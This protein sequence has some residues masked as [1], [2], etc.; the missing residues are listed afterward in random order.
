[1]CCPGVVGRAGPSPG[2]SGGLRLRIGNLSAKGAFPMKRKWSIAFLFSLVGLCLLFALPAFTQNTTARGALGGIVQDTTSATVPDASVTVTGPIGSES[3]VTND[4]GRFLFPSLI[5]GTYSVRV[6]KQGF[7]V[8]EIKNVE[9]LINSTK[10][11]RVTIEP[12]EISQT[13][14]VIA[15]VFTVDATSAAVS[16]DLPDTFY[17]DVPL[18][19][20]VSAIFYLSPG[21]VSGLGT[22]AANPS[23][24]GSTGLEN[25]YVADGVMLND[26]AFGGMGVFSRVYGSLGT[27]ITLSFIK[28]VQVNSAAFGPQ[29]GHSAGGVVQM[30]TKAGGTETHGVI[31]GY[32]QAPSMSALY[33]NG[34]DYNPV[35]LVGRHLHQGQYEGD[36]ELGGHVPLFKNHLFYFGSVDPTYTFQLVAPAISSPL[37][38]IT[39]GQETRRTNTLSYSAKLTWQIDK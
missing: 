4:D 21:V 23:I 14:E 20:N 29:Y 19:R 38:T 28:E 9:V 10:S 8:E 1:M 30:I 22:G 27:G 35:N 11:I 26:P 37:Y 15:P 12:G 24:S 39:G 36:F 13:V 3:G 31:G 2:P 32:F 17:K 6:Q 34:D 18:G 33:R 5:P 25:L 7:K 16:S